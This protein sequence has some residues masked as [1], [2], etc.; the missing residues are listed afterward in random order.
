VPTDSNVAVYSLRNYCPSIV[1]QGIYSNCVGWAVS[2]YAMSTR[3]YYL[4]GLKDD[5]LKKMLSLDPNHLLLFKSKEK[6]VWKIRGSNFK[7]EFEYLTRY[8]A[9]FRINFSEDNS[10]RNKLSRSV[11]LKNWNRINLMREGLESVKIAILSGKPVVFGLSISNDIFEKD[12][13]GDTAVFKSN[14]ISGLNYY[15]AM[16][17]IGFDDSIEGGSFELVTSY[18]PNFGSLGKIYITYTDFF[19]LVKEAYVF[20]LEF[21]RFLQGGLENVNLGISVFEE[22]DSGI[23]MHLIKNQ[24][25]SYYIGGFKDGIRTGIGAEIF[26]EEIIM[27]VDNQRVYD[28]RF[29]SNK[30]GYQEFYDVISFFFQ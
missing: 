12:F 1:D 2:Y 18:G 29:K 13:G 9:P 27:N 23:E 28:G 30:N 25:N 24:D 22:S 3:L 10:E 6:D 15:Q 8:G 26:D 16:T 19:R 7:E 4:M 20:E 21:P 5:N 14:E 17:I 11:K